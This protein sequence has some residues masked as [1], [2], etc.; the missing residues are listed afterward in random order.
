MLTSLNYLRGF[1][2]GPEVETSPSNAGSE[3]LIPGWRAEIPYASPPKN[4]NTKTEGI[5]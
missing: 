3:G 4:Q 5:L 2:G 1:Y